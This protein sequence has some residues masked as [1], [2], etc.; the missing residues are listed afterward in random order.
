MKA[1][2]S[3]FTFL[4]GALLGAEPNI[5]LVP[6]TKLGRRNSAVFT[7]IQWNTD[8]PWFHKP[9]PVCKVMA[10]PLAV[11]PFRRLA[12][13]YKIPPFKKKWTDPDAGRP[14]DG[15][16][17]FAA[18]QSSNR[19]AI[20]NPRT[21]LFKV[22]LA[23]FRKF[24]RDQHRMAVVKPLPTKEEC[25]RIGREW[26]EKLDID[27]AEFSRQGDWPEGFMIAARAHRVTRTHPV[28]QKETVAEI[29]LAVRFVQEI[30]GLPVFWNGLG[31]NVMFEIADG[32]EFCSVTG[33][34][35]TWEKIGD[36]PVL[37]RE[38]IT[39]ALKDGFH[40]SYGPIHCDRLE[41]VKVD[42]EAYHSEPER[43]QTDFPLVYTLSCKLHGGP[44]DGLTRSILMPALKQHRNKYSLPATPGKEDPKNEAF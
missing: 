6:D 8:S 29:G 25:I 36:L 34:L 14:I 20:A 18:D 41:I 19:Y 22:G 13:E 40:W 16:V 12:T 35:R 11:E 21:R 7:E 10:K 23:N 38:E 2:I 43:P 28:T 5:S 30:G 37:D 39:A 32:G 27:E 42:L 33:C 3:V 4:L 17:Y 9:A 26:L 15:S 1:S 24:E 31:G 44:N